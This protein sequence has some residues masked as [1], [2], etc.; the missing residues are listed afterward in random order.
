MSI[1]QRIEN[2]KLGSKLKNKI[3]LYECKQ[4]V[5]RVLSLDKFALLPA[6]ET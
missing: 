6:H 4:I 3:A 2:T 5:S 1:L